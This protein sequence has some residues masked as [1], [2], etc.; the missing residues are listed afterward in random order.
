M[1]LLVDRQAVIFQYSNICIKMQ[2]K[3]KMHN[4]TKSLFLHLECQC[5]DIIHAVTFSRSSYNLNLKEGK[6]FVME[7]CAR[8]ST[9]CDLYLHSQERYKCWRSYMTLVA[10]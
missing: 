7:Q 9:C 8:N 5:K 2:D 3:N 1:Q 6:K 10:V 4:Y